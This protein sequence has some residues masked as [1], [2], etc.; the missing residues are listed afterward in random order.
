VK[1]A[2]F[3]DFECPACKHF[4]STLKSVLASY[5]ANRVSLVFV[6]FPL[7]QHRFASIAARAAE[8]AAPGG[9]FATFHDLLFAKQDSLGLKSWGSFGFEVGI[10][11]SARFSRCVAGTEVVSR[12][13]AG[14]GI[15]KRLEIHATPTVM[16]NGWRFPRPPS[17]TELKN[18]ID[19]LLAEAR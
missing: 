4:E 1:I 8:C 7:R 10:R 3:A 18:L 19:K 6:H 9:R 16:V 2:E 5:P 15:G 11:D 12:I 17:E 14:E 13:A